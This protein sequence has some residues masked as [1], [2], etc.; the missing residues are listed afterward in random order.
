MAR[1]PQLTTATLISDPFPRVQLATSNPAQWNTE[2]ETFYE[3]HAAL[4]K[5]DYI[6]RIAQSDR[7]RSMMFGRLSPSSSSKTRTEDKH[8]YLINYQSTFEIQ[9]Y[10]G[11]SAVDALVNLDF[12]HRWLSA[13]VAERRKHALVGLA[14]AGAQAKNLNA[15][16]ACCADIL[17]MGYLTEEGE[18]VLGLLREVITRHSVVNPGRK[19]PYW[20]PNREWEEVRER[21][22]SN[23]KTTEDEKFD[24]L[25]VLM[26]RAKLICEH[27]TAIISFSSGLIAREQTSSS[28]A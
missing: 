15:A 22:R 25:E 12:E 2:W 11:R 23:P 9:D 24:L 27:F 3:L 10:V 6:M 19:E 8:G 18:V 14:N 4:T 7:Q 13:P 1:R 28:K 5:P 16:R 17:R 20:F 26:L 21:Q